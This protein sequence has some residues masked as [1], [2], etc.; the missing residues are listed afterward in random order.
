MAYIKINKNNY[1]YNISQIVLKAG[2][3]ERVA[4]VLKD[5]AYGHGLEII[6]KLSHE[7]GIKQAVV[8]DLKEAEIIKPYFDQI[9]VLHDTP[10][11]DEKL[12]FAVSDIDILESIPK[13]IKIELKIDTGMHRNGIVFSEIERAFKT[14]QRK[15]LNLCGI[16]TH[17]RSADVL[18]SELFWQQ[19]QFEKVK[20]EVQRHGFENIRFHSNNSAALLRSNC[21][22]E[23]MARTGIAIYGYNELPDIYDRI[24][25][26]PVMSL[27]AKRASTREL[28]KGQRVGYGG[29]FIAPKDMIVSTYDIGYGDGWIRGD[30]SDP[31]ILPNGQPILGRVSM[32]FISLEGD[33]AEVCIMDDAQ[34]AAKHFG[35]ISYEMTTMISKDIKRVVV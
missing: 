29:D 5:N 11:A 17:F 32:D 6:A 8:I 22:S 33:A 10:V 4:V 12:S 35:T 16:M 13:D 15:N 18:G 20:K 24:E 31:Y 30:S 19:K 1:F 9:L 21:F 25:L 28:K 3:K 27:W 23:D 7:F 2:S 14:I 34:Q 26:K